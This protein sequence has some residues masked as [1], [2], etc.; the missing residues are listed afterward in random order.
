MASSN[1][2]RPAV[3]LSLFLEDAERSLVPAA[4]GNVSRAARVDASDAPFYGGAR[5]HARTGPIMAQR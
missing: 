2:L 4:I 1:G 5:W 3:V